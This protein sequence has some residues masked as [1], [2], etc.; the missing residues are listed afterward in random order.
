MDFGRSWCYFWNVAKDEKHHGSA[1]PLTKCQGI[2]WYLTQ[3]TQPLPSP[4]SPPPPLP[5]SSSD[6]PPSPWSKTRPIPLLSF[7]S[8]LGRK[9]PKRDRNIYGLITYPAVLCL[10]PAYNQY[11]STWFMPISSRHVA[12]GMAP[13]PAIQNLGVALFTSWGRSTAKEREDFR[14]SAARFKRSPTVS[15]HLFSS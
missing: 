14:K 10:C 7:S 4:P 5:P 15:P 9:L 12:E 2:A 3:R 6:D 11:F 8:L 1:L 13:R